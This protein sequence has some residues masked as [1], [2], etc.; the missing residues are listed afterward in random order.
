ME[1]SIFLAKVIGITG[2]I[3][4]LL[5]II[6]YKFHLEMEKNAS[7]D[8]SIIYPS[9]FVFLMLGTLLI[10]SHSIWTMDW[11]IIIT[12][13]GWSMLLKGIMRIL[14]PDKV[15]SIIHKKK[16]KK[17]FILAEITVFIICLYLTF[18]GFYT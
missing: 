15:R 14:I 3:S 4:T 11:R 8:L 10:V 13:L 1:T 9:G 5:I 16:D 7:K 2:S 18:K 17:K 12:L 6:H